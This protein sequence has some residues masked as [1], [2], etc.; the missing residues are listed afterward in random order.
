MNMIPRDKDHDP[1]HPAIVVWQVR[2]ELPDDA[3]PLFSE[4]L[5]EDFDTFST[6]RD[7]SDHPWIV[8]CI[9]QD[10]PDTDALAAKISIL[11]ETA[12]IPV[13][14][15]TLEEVPNIDWLEY[16]YQTFK[17][18]TVGRF[19]IHGSHYKDDVPADKIPLIIDAATAFGTG[20]HGTTKGCVYAVD[21]LSDK[22]KPARCLDMGC[23]SGILAFA[24]AKAF[25][26]PVLAVDNDPES[27]KVT[28]EKAELNGLT[29]LVTAD[30]GDGFNTPSVI[31]QTPFDLVTANILADPLI[32]MAP[33]L[34]GV[35]SADG[36]VVLS[37]LL[38]EQEERVRF[39]YETLGMEKIADFPIDGWQAI[40]MKKG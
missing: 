3:L 30:C 7:D 1:E 11:A 26:V 38:Q 29:E 23:G 28:T 14:Q 27:T 24:A 13:P 15:F 39:A 16:V 35:L 34:V 32:E 9:T 20:E 12:G 37:G 4:S 17:P 25:N 19:F 36:V 18:F 22:L 31:A 5:E 8:E 21:Y 40:I 10:K 33:A 6:R 2:F